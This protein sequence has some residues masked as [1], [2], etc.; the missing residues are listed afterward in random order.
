M[1]G[2]G[3][4]EEYC[5]DLLDAVGQCLLPEVGGGID[6]DGLAFKLHQN[7]RA[8]ALIPG[9][10]RQAGITITADSRNPNRSAGAQ[11]SNSHRPLEMPTNCIRRSARTLSS[12]SASSSVTF[13]C[14]LF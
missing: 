6:E 14:V 10:F 12:S 1:V 3:V 9:I 2:M 8:Q 7:R 11:E 5:I 13:P 4:S